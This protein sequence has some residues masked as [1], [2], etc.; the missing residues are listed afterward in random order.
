MTTHIRGS[1]G[2]S[3][4]AGKGA[5]LL[6]WVALAVSLAPARALA[7]EPEQAL[8]TPSAA[9]SADQGSPS[10]PPQV[11]TRSVAADQAFEEKEPAGAKPE[12]DREPWEGAPDRAF[13]EEEDE[14]RPSPRAAQADEAEHEH[15]FV[16]GDAVRLAYP[17]DTGPARPWFE[18]HPLEGAVHG[19]GAI[20][21]AQAGYAVSGA[22]WMALGP[23]GV[24]LFGRVL[25]LSSFG[26]SAPRT[27]WSGVDAEGAL[28]LP[29]YVGRLRVTPLVAV[30]GGWLET[31]APSQGGG[32]VPAC[33]AGSSP[34]TDGSFTCTGGPHGSFSGWTLKPR[35]DLGL[36]FLFPA[37]RLEQHAIAVAGHLGLTVDPWAQS[38][39]WVGTLGPPGVAGRPVDMAVG[40]PAWLVSLG[41]GV[42]WI[43]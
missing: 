11:A 32:V 36:E 6:A 26:D 42:A 14:D 5:C 15:F 38:G 19:E 7:A 33:G 22:G 3:N 21:Q 37:R 17:P 39:Y 13:D 23:V 25:G 20:G 18:A 1:A 4:P 9:V 28:L 8:P 16:W 2:T 35:G 31:N 12:K 27:T 40:E 43:R 24:G 29:L 34:Q 10:P 41:I 30:G